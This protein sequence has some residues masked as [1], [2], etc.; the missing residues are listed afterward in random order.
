MVAGRH[1]GH[2][3]TLIREPKAD[4][5]D[6]G[7]RPRAEAHDQA[8]REHLGGAHLEAYPFGVPRGRFPEEPPI[9]F[10]QQLAPGTHLVPVAHRCPI[11]S[12]HWYDTPSKKC[13]ACRGLGKVLGWRVE[14]LKH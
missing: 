12:P 10:T 6:R 9:Q 4:R 7:Q 2:V 5:D 8:E 11:C 14:K 13:P 1:T 3:C